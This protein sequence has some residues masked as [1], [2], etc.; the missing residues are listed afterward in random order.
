MVHLVP[1]QLYSVLKIAHLILAIFRRVGCEQCVIHKNM[2][3]LL[4]NTASQTEANIERLVTVLS[5]IEN[6]GLVAE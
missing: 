1:I 4:Q 6:P 3:R 5:R 2:K